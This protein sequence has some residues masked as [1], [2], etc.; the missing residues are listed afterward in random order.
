MNQTIK[1]EARRAEPMAKDL[2]VSTGSA[3]AEL[4]RAEV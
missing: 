2:T 4:G 1:S 3:T